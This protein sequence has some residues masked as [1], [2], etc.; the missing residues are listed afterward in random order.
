MDAPLT[1]LPEL[2]PDIILAV[3]TVW[4]LDKFT[5]DNGATCVVP[6]SHRTL[7]KPSWGYDPIEDD[8]PRPDCRETVEAGLVNLEP[9]SRRTS[10]A[11]HRPRRI[12][13]IAVATR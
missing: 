6:G 13:W 7:K 10:I 12:C 11:A 2:L 5:T 9:S 8:R 3:Q 1:I 4:I